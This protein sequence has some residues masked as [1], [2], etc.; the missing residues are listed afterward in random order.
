MK[1]FS[2]L[3]KHERRALFPSLSLRKKPDIIG[4]LI[5]LL[6][7]ALVIGIFL[8]MVS[9]VTKN[10]VALKLNNVSD[11]TARSA[12]LL[13][14]LYTVIIVALALLCLEKMRNTLASKA[15]RDIFLRLPV[16][17]KALFLSK[18][19]ALMLWNYVTA[20]FLILPI[21]AIFYFI[22]SPGSEFFV[23]TALVILF[24]P[25]V[26]FLLATLLL[27]PYIHVI[28]FLSRHYFITFLLLSSRIPRFSTS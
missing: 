25:M 9:T 12:E 13:T 5:S 27:I 11:P 28:N 21:N 20:V 24:L 4:G 8:Y 26:S 22:L 10:Y 16:S 2:I 6:I 14:V 17:S 19:S 3:F 7:S 18:F 15:G 23:G 1:T